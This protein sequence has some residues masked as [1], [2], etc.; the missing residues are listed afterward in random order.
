MPIIQCLKPVSIYFLA[1]YTHKKNVATSCI[2][3]AKFVAIFSHV[4]ISMIFLMTP[5]LKGVKSCVLTPSES[6]GEF[7]GGQ[8]CF[9]SRIYVIIIAITVSSETL[10]ETKERTANKQDLLPQ[11]FTGAAT[12]FPSDAQRASHISSQ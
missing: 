8:L 4:C 9:I 6:K 3:S 2:F 10:S 5:L 12:I 7:L 11:I 1:N